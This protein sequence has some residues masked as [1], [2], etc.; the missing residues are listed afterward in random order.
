MKHEIIDRRVLLE[1]QTSAEKYFYYFYPEIGYKYTYC[2][3]DNKLVHETL[4]KCKQLKKISEEFILVD[5]S[6]LKSLGSVYK[7]KTNKLI[8]FHDINHKC[9]E[10]MSSDPK[11][12]EKYSDLLIKC[13]REEEEEEFPPSINLLCYDSKGKDFY[14]R[15]F[16]VSSTVDINTHYNDDFINISEDIINKLN[17]TNK[18]IVL[19]HGIPGSGKS[20]YIR[21]LVNKLNKD[22]IYVTP[23]MATKLTSPEIIPFLI[24]ECQN[25]VLIIE[26]AEN[27]LSKRKGGDNQ[28]VSNLLN[29]SDGLLSD[30]LGIS[31]VATFNTELENI[32][33]A[34]LRPGRLLGKY[35]FDKLSIEK[36]QKLLDML[37]GSNVYKVT[38]PMTLGEIYNLKS[39]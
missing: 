22:V 20:N 34:L 4:L 21:Y 10:I 28:A 1:A 17:T 30:C 38:N 12:V 7:D 24:S 2:R 37:Y 11:H 6:G 32:D 15:S 35:Y 33:E 25:H 29:L 9:V 31:I 8:L 39:I 18:G 19:L 5:V 3:L 36:S 13:L 16:E 23:D 26:D 14:L 27:I